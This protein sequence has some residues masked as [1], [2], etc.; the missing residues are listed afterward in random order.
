MNHE[1]KSIQGNTCL[2]LSTI[3]NSLFIY[4]FRLFQIC[5]LFILKQDQDMISGRVSEHGTLVTQYHTV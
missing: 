1:L 3:S 2:L 5:T 4:F